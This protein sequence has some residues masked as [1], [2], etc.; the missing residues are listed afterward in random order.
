MP[1]PATVT[2]IPV[3]GEILDLS[4]GEPAQGYIDFTVPVALVDQA[5]NVVLGPDRF[6]A[7]LD[8]DGRFSIDL[9]ATDDPDLVPDPAADSWQYTV[10]MRTTVLAT[11]FKA[12]VPRN[13]AGTLRFTGMM[14]QGT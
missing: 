6:R 2:L 14:L 8:I 13:T 11:T 7:Q 9:V 5:N 1:L 10:T 12:N 3:E 4:T